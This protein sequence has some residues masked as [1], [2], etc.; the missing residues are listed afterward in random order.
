MTIRQTTNKQH[1]QDQTPVHWAAEAG[2]RCRIDSELRY[3]PLHCRGL[4]KGQDMPVG[5][6]N[7]V[8]A[9]SWGRSRSPSIQGN[10]PLARPASDRALR[11]VSAH[12]PIFSPPSL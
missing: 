7:T 12:G 11:G 1:H 9:V 5:W 4:N 8:G 10:G 6:F 2:S 3:S